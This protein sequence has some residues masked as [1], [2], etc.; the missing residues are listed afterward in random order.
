MQ[1]K[2]HGQVSSITPSKG[3]YFI[4]QQKAFYNYLQGDPVTV[5]MAAYVLK[6]PEKNL[7]RYKRELEKAN[8]LWRVFQGSCKFTGNRAWFITTDPLKAAKTSKQ[9]KLF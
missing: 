6:I 4:A 1:N 5:A 9:L 8:K 3:T 7:T 2:L